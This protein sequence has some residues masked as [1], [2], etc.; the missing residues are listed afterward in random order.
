MIGTYEFNVSL[1]NAPSVWTGDL[2]VARPATF[3]GTG[4]FAVPTYTGTTSLSFHPTLVAQ[5]GFV[6]PAFSGQAVG[7]LTHPTIFPTS[8]GGLFGWWQFQSDGFDSTNLL[9]T[10]S[11][12]GGATA[13]AGHL[14]LDG[15]SG[16]A[17]VSDDPFDVGTSSFTIGVRAKPSLT[18]PSDQTIVSKRNNSSY[19]G[20]SL[21]REGTTGKIVF[22]TSDT[23]SIPFIRVATLSAVVTGDEHH[24]AV[25]VSRETDTVSL[26]LDG[27]QQESTSIAGMGSISNTVPMSF[28]DETGQSRWSG[29]LADIRFYRRSLSP[30]E[31]ATVSSGGVLYGDIPVFGTFTVPSYVGTMAKP[32]PHPLFASL[33][34]EAIPNFFGNAGLL[35]THPTVVSTATYGLPAFAGNAVF[36]V[37]HPI[38][39]ATGVRTVPVYSGNSEVSIN[40]GIFDS[41]ATFLMAVF[42]GSTTLIVPKSTT[43][44]SGTFSIPIYVGNSELIIP[45]PILS[46]SSM[47]E[48]PVYTGTENLIISHPIFS[49]SGIYEIPSYTSNAALLFPHPILSASALN[50]YDAFRYD[51]ISYIVNKVD[52]KIFIVKDIG[53]EVFIVKKEDVVHFMGDFIDNN[54]V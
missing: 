20:W 51:V 24:I 52:G 27:V 46:T 12:L 48:V 44:T 35:A 30:L 5:G 50:R 54:K 11:L 41:T 26:Y 8:I 3:S 13:T 28:G 9:H 23:G 53:S 16:Y 37:V 45:H 31:A 42:R 19:R 38:F 47:F 4:S 15:T 21:F 39:S 33:A 1:Y 17:V 6:I 49:G 40:H 18:G 29:T 10:A 22:E 25:V 34:S 36:Q 7:L 43:S 2:S 14:T 32:S